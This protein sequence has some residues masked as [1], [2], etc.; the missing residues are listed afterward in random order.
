MILGV[1]AVAYFISAITS[2]PLIIFF[3][4]LSVHICAGAYWQSIGFF[5]GRYIL[6]E[7]RGISIRP[8]PILLVLL[9]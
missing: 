5:R 6:N 9:C 1:S 7:I 3:A 4:C 8:G 2:S